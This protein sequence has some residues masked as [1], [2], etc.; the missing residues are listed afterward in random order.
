MFDRSDTMWTIEDYEAGGSPKG[1]A[2]AGDIEGGGLPA[3]YIEIVRE[4]S[5]A[6]RASSAGSMGLAP[7]EGPGVTAGRSG[8]TSSNTREQ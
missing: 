5:A 1:E 2:D 3:D 8:S 4:A 6:A 7:G